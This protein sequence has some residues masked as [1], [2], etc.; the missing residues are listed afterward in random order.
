VLSGISFNSLFAVERIQGTFQLRSH[1]LYG[2]SRNKEQLTVPGF[3][4]QQ[5]LCRINFES[6]VR[7]EN[8]GKKRSISNFFK[9]RGTLRVLFRIFCSSAISLLK[10]YYPITSANR[11]VAQVVCGQDEYV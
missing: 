1:V 4:Y 9:S 3:W 2:S 5:R 8:A 7:K 6:S 11:I 10:Q